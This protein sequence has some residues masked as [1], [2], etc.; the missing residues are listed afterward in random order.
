MAGKS[1]LYRKKTKRSLAAGFT[2]LGSATMLAGCG[3]SAPTDEQPAAAAPQSQESDKVYAYRSVGECTAAKIYSEQKCEEAYDAAR[4]ENEK[5]AKVYDQKQACEAEYGEGNCEKRR[6]GFSGV[7]MGY[8][9]ARSMDGNRYSYG[10]LYNNKKSGLLSTA[11]PA[12][13]QNGTKTAYSISSGGFAGQNTVDKM[14]DQRRRSGSSLAATGGFGGRS[15][16]SA[17][18]ASVGSKGG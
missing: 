4:E 3:S 18:K 12:V 15:V 9:I 2:A 8:I 17:A 1:T 13:M 11:S 7:L 16:A 10:G 5:T 14:Q 6:S